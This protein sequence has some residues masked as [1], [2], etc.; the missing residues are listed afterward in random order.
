MLLSIWVGTYYISILVSRGKM[1]DN[2]EKKVM[3][4]EME[5]DDRILKVNWIILI[6]NT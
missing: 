6:N 1:T 2:D 3:F 5:L 4:H